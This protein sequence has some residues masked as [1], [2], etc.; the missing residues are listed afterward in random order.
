MDLPGETTDVIGTPCLNTSHADLTRYLGQR[1]RE[2]GTFAVDF[3]NV[4]I[5]A[6]RH[7]DAEFARDLDAFDVFVP[8]SQVLFFAVRLLGGSMP[9]RVYGPD[10][11]ARAFPAL[12]APHT[13]YLLGGAPDTL[14]RLESALREK[15]PGSQI[16][17]RHDGYYPPAED[18]AIVDEINALSPDFIWVGLGTPKQQAWIARNRGSLR[19]GILLAVGFAFDV[20]AG[21][22]RDAPRLLQR[23]GLTWLYRFASEPRRLW[24]RYLTYNCLFLALLARQLARRGFGRQA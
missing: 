11:L 6:M 22:K 4:H 7:T 23:L 13:H 19:R 5:V 18:A 3:T 14:A 9:E 12:G 17:G 15:A 20:N 21:T 10:F 2:E 24:K 8:D 1:C 16:V